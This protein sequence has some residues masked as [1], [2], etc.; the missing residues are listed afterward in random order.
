MIDCYLDENEWKKV[1]LLSIQ[2]EVKKKGS[3]FV[4][5]LLKHYNDP[6]NGMIVEG[7]MIAAYQYMSEEL[8]KPVEE[9][10]LTRGIRNRLSAVE[11]AVREK[12]KRQLLADIKEVERKLVE[13]PGTS[14]KSKTDLENILKE[15]N[16]FIDEPEI[17]TSTMDKGA[18]ILIRNY[19]KILYASEAVCTGAILYQERIK[20]IHSGP[21]AFFKKLRTKLSQLFGKK[22]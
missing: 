16:I 12:I 15:F 4:K 19:L 3:T 21:T 22:S 6:I 8:E 20:R 18:Q 17:D 9:L 10:V 14:Y 2:D 13:Q 7:D 11:E 5:L 1:C